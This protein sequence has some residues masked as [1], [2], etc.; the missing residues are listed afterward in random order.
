MESDIYCTPRA[1]FQMIDQ[2]ENLIDRSK[3]SLPTPYK[4]QGPKIV[5]DNL[6]S[7]RKVPLPPHEPLIPAIIE[8]NKP[9]LR[10]VNKC[11][12]PRPHQRPTAQMLCDMLL[13]FC[14]S[15]I[16]KSVLHEAGKW[17]LSKLKCLVP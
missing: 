11:L 3:K 15:S 16:I 4:P 7:E 2:I 1:L 12:K 9:L 8:Q 13:D 14:K 6:L 10:I 5:Y 17:V